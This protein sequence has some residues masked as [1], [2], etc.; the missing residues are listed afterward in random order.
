M[1]YHHPFR[2][3]L[4]QIELSY[5]YKG[6]LFLK[7][8]IYFPAYAVSYSNR[9][10]CFRKKY[11]LGN[12]RHGAFRSRRPIYVSRAIQSS[13]YTRLAGNVRIF[14]FVVLNMKWIIICHY[15]FDDA[16]RCVVGG[17]RWCF[18]CA[19]VHS[20]FVMKVNYNVLTYSVENHGVF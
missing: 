1:Y 20:M 12:F 5:N 8:E 13:T 16:P 17:L 15:V 11:W 10:H 4:K 6:H 3:N 7:C 14:H 9:E 2:R 18:P 19:I